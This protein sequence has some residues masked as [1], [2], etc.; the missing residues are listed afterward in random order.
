[1]ALRLYR[2]KRGVEG[3]FPGVEYNDGKRVLL[4]GTKGDGALGW[5][6]L[7]AVQRTAVRGVGLNPASD[8][9]GYWCDSD[10]VAPVI[11]EGVVDPDADIRGIADIEEL[12]LIALA[13][14]EAHRAD[15]AKISEVLIEEADDRDWCEE[16]DSIIA[17]QINPHLSVKMK[18][19]TREMCTI[20]GAFDGNQWVDEHRAIP[21]E[22]DQSREAAALAWATNN[23]GDLAQVRQVR[24]C[25]E[26]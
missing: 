14:R 7:S 3:E 24:A 21:V 16:Y 2:F 5:K 6:K 25:G 19:R 22:E 12:R 13:S 17:E 18:F 4:L 11:V 26:A 10:A 23:Y 20:F 1:M 15:V 9:V 8:L